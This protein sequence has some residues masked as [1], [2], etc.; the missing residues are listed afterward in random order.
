M[1]NIKIPAEEY[2]L[3]F[4]R[5]SGTGGQNVNKV[6]TKATL[7]W[8]AL[9]SPSLPPAVRERFIAKYGKRLNEAGV[10]TLTSQ[11]F[12]T[13][14]LNI[15]DVVNKLHEM[16]ESIATPPKIRRPTKPTKSSVRE[17]IKVKKAHGDKKKNRSKVSFD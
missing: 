16:I 14:H 15:S 5:S 7:K 2:D 12:R 9:H 6:N 11:A 17:R 1:V 3:S 4:S 8:N 13:Q 10:L